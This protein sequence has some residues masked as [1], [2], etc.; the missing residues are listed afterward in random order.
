M[1]AIA[2]LFGPPLVALLSA[3]T[4]VLLPA[5]LPVRAAGAVAASGA[6]PGAVP[7]AT[8]RARTGT[9]LVDNGDPAKRITLVLLGDGYTAAELPRYRTQAAAVWTALTAVEP[10]RT[11]QHFF[12]VRRVDLVSARSGLRA[13]SPLAM[14]F[15]CDGTPRLLCADDSAVDRLAGGSGGPQYPIA[16]ANSSQY[17]G[18]GGDGATTLAAGSPDAAKILQHEMGHTVGGLGDEYDSAPAEAGY[19]N[20]ADSDASAL[21]AGH[22][23]WW[24]WLGAEDPTGGVVGAYRSANGLFRPTEDSVMRTLGGSYNLP[25][26]EAVIESVYRQVRPIDHTL[27]EPGTLDRRPVLRV[28]PLLLVGPRQ[29]Q[30]SWQVDGRPAPAAELGPDGDSL[31]TSRL[32]PPPG[33]CSTVTVTV[34]DTTPWVRDE[35]F[36]DLRMTARATWTLRG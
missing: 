34:R 3:L 28:F 2:R 21:R 17:G 7:G 32:I 11:Y 27:P 14:H 24:R 25:S 26:R 19:P 5:L 9:M 22:R 36:R 8:T 1:R 10:F 12:D 15:G 16:L 33:G 20:L 6:V 35:D 31:D 13:G 4:L 29:L 18:E 30:V 23:K